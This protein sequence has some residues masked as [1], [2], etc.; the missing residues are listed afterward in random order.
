MLAMAVGNA[1][2][3]IVLYSYGGTDGQFVKFIG[4]VGSP[5]LCAYTYEVLNRKLSESKREYLQGHADETPS[6]R[7][8]LGTLYA[9]AWIYSILEKVQEFAGVS[10]EAE[11][12]SN[13][14]TA[15]HYPKIGT[16][17]MKRGKVYADEYAAY[18]AGLAEGEKVSLHRP[19]KQEARPLLA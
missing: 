18:E 3:C 4:E 9:E 17:N 19:M 8:R 14:Y 2:G 10:E 1:F 13:A 11:R 6:R 5:E 15:R 12:A 16:V 7:R